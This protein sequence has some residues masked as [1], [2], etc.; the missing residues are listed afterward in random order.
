MSYLYRTLAAQKRYLRGYALPRWVGLE[1]AR[2][3]R[4]PILGKDPKNPNYFYPKKFYCYVGQDLGPKYLAHLDTWPSR[5]QQVYQG[6][7]RYYS[8]V[9]GRDWDFSELCNVPTFQWTY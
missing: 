4:A 5:R 9:Y 2:I 3:T 7:L 1:G 6:Y 8:V